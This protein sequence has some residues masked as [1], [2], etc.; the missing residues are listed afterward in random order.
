MADTQPTI[1]LIAGPNGS[2][3]TRLSE[4]LIDEGWFASAAYIN[5]D[6]IARHQY[7][8]W[9]SPT[10]R[11]KA[12]VR[13]AGIIKTNLKAKKSFALETVLSP[14]G[15]SL[16]HRA[17]QQGY[18]TYLYFIGTSDPAINIARV[19]ARIREGGHH[20][21][22][23]TIV[24]RYHEAMATLPTAMAVADFAF[25]YDNSRDDHSAAR[26]FHTERGRLAEQFATDLPSWAADA[27]QAM[28]TRS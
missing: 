25:I 21:P 13:A 10:A 1:T 28:P 18:V 15:V 9:D 8:D 24:N 17:K 27:L 23:T 12:I 2:G 5:P 16:L 22:E 11:Q 3:K 14:S 7:G 26:L 6:H 20:I 19:A 4:T